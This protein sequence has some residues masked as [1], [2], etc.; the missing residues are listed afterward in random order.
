MRVVRSQGREQRGVWRILLGQTA[1]DCC[2]PSVLCVTAFPD[3][4]VTAQVTQGAGVCPETCCPQDRVARQR[5]SGERTGRCTGSPEKPVKALARVLSKAQRPAPHFPEWGPRCDP[6][7]NKRF[8]QCLLYAGATPG[9]LAG[10]LFARVPP[11]THT[12]VY[13]RRHLRA[14]ADVQRGAQNARGCRAGAG[15]APPKEGVHPRHHRQGRYPPRAICPS[16][17][18]VYRCPPCAGCCRSV[19]KPKP[20]PAPVSGTLGQREN[21]Q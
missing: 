14:T 20:T 9:V 16:P 17:T 12:A 1:P 7:F 15:H 11:A 18:Q 10:H 6:T 19:S 3:T 8:R 5:A 21:K 2:L 4:W 13:L